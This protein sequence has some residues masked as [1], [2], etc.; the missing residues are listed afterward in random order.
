MG[1]FSLHRAGDRGGPYH[2]HAYPRGVQLRD[3]VHGQG[4]RHRIRLWRVCAHGP[5]NS[6]AASKSAGVKGLAANKK[7]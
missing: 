3:T 2:A 6:G 1:L 5:T 7:G 4:L